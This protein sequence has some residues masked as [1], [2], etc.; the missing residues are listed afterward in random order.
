MPGPGIEVRVRHHRACRSRTVSS[1]PLVRRR[2]SAN[3]RIVS[4]RPKR[5]SCAAV[6]TFTKLMSIKSFRMTR[7]SPWL[8]PLAPATVTAASAVN[9]PANAARR[10]KSSCC[11]SERRSYDQA[12]VSRIVCWRA[13]ASRALPRSSRNRSSICATSASR[14][15]IV[16]RAAASSMARGRPS[17]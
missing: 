4:N 13:G 3:S 12:I 7:I 16:M 14:V 11:S 5:G 10:R 2:S 8:T 9:P 1:S 6:S 17:R 15:S